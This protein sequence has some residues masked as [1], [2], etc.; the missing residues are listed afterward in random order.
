[1]LAHY[2]L[3]TRKRLGQHYL[4]DPHVLDKIIRAAA[5][6]PQDCVLEIGPGIGAVTQALANHAG[7]VCAVELDALLV[8]V[9]ADLFGAMPHVTIHH[10]DIL[11][12]DLFE[13]LAPYAGMRLKVVA[14][15]PYYV[16]TPV[17]M[18]LLENG[19]RFESLTV[20]VQ[21]EVAERMAAS[22][23]TKAYGA[24]TLGV[25]YRAETQIAAYVPPNCF[26]P[27]P[28][29]DSAVV[30]MVTQPVT[31]DAAQRDWLFQIIQ[32]A[33]QQRRK[34]LVNNLRTL[35][36]DPAPKGVVCRTL[37]DKEALS[38][39]I[40]GCGFPAEVRGEMLSLEDFK[41]LAKALAVA[42]SGEGD[43]F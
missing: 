35:L 14:N 19:P 25:Q 30:H 9:L 6:G 17:V 2:G 34:T 11:K 15:L 3:H 8:P 4:V 41:R 16:T 23:G 32:A 33:F 13:L 26:M 7:Q 36:S 10:A 39:M 42:V 1:M 40:T 22:P 21:R 20:M 37:P 18:R 5:L 24:L 38:A 12:L 27:R 31:E 28:H 29:V 43:A